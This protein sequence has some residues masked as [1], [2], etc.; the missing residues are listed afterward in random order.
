MA[1]IKPAFNISLFPLPWF[2]PQKRRARHLACRV[3]EVYE[4]VVYERVT[5]ATNAMIFKKS[6]FHLTL[7]V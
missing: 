3:C 1:T 4:V 2:L 5:N 6:A 7:L